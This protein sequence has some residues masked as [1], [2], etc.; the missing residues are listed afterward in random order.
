MPSAHNFYA[1]VRAILEFLATTRKAKRVVIV[2]D[3]DEE[4]RLP[5]PDTTAPPTAV[6]FI[7]NE[8]QAGIL[9]ALEGKAMRTDQLVNKVG[10]DR[11]QLFRKPGGIEELKVQGLV[12]HHERAGY[13]RHDCPPEELVQHQ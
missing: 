2:L 8:V 11:R 4:V 3:D 12:S 13:Y 7:P 9:A 6:P 1:A 10:C 5:I